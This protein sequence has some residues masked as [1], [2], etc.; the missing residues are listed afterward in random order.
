[1]EP[2][3]EVAVITLMIFGTGI[4]LQQDAAVGAAFGSAFFM[5]S[6]KDHKTAARFVYTLISAGAGY[7]AGLALAGPWSMLAA[8]LGAAGA[9]AFLD[10]LTQGGEP[11]GLVKWVVDVVRGRK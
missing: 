10:G 1:M 4:V 2:A 6:A 8:I 11:N 7:A 3:T 5:I 9:V